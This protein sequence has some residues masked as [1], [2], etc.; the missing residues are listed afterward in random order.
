MFLNF[1]AFF[2]IGE[3]FQNLY[4]VA[5]DI[6]T[7]F[8]ARFELV[9]KLVG[10]VFECF[11][12]VLRTLCRELRDGKVAFASPSKLLRALFQTLQICCE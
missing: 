2:F 4:E 8:V 5:Q 10:S 12:E 7:F 9:R 1:E 11:L 6:L 3:I